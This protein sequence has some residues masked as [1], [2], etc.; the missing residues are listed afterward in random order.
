MGVPSPPLAT[1]QTAQEGGATAVRWGRAGALGHKSQH[2]TLPLEKPLGYRTFP[3]DGMWREGGLV[4][5][6]FSFT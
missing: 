4:L 2:V 5:S 1:G 6:G 3:A